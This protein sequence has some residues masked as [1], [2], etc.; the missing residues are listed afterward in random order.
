MALSLAIIGAVVGIALGLRFK[1]LVLVPAIALAAISALIVGIARGY[2]FWS[3][4]LAIV[5]VGSAIQLGYLIGIFLAERI[6]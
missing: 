5:I 2:S 3:I 1:V 4:V 6:R